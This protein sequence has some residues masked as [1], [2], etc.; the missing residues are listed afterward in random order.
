M[1]SPE[2]KISSK[3]TK[4]LK[5]CPHLRN[6]NVRHY[7]MIGSYGIK[8]YGFQVTFKFITSIQN[9]IQ[10]HQSVQKLH[11]SQKFK[12]SSLW[13]G[14]SRE[15]KNNGSM[16]RLMPSTSYKISSKSTNLFKSYW[17][18]PSCP[19][20]KFRCTPFGNGWSYV[21]IKD[22]IEVTFNGITSLPNFMKINW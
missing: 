21:I 14:W 6:L 8:I 4:C 1:S 5:S 11:P 3:S 17:E 16:P 7:G 10:I 20:Q 9:V 15:I 18:V 19:P 22:V 2:Y 12:C 13:N